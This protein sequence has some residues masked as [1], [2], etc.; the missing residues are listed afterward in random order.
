MSD[1]RRFAF[2]M[3]LL[4]SAILSAGPLFVRLADVGPVQSAF[5]RLALGAPF[6][7]ALVRLTEGRL[8]RPGESSNAR[9]L[10]F[11]GLFFAAD[12]ASWH[13]GI[14]RT[15]LANSTLLANSTAFLFPIWGYAVARRW[16]ARQAALAL[17]LAAAGILTLTS[18]SASLSTTNLT[19]D[20]LC[21][22]AAVF[23]TGY[24][25][26][27]DKARG[28]MSALS[29]LAYATTAGAIA[30]FPAAVL[31]NGPFWPEDWRPLLILALSSQVAG[32]G[33]IIFALPH[34]RPISSGLGLLIQPAFA[35]TLGFLWFNEV[36]SAVDA[37]GMALIFVAIL[38][39]RRQS[40][41]RPAIETRVPPSLGG[42][43]APD[44]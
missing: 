4:G 29:A 41:E 28:G 15:T 10:V 12:L 20:L 16:P 39:V 14:G 35:A 18:Q 8:P 32:Q 9:W 40:S 11:A 17:V 2:P 21:L 31:S 37:G 26:V 5:W 3:F 25:V 13:F 27:M 34:L 24:L 7:F 1:F 43:Q 38:L 44:R 23:Y 19:G 6:L 33:L 30:L 42:A 22:L 36:L